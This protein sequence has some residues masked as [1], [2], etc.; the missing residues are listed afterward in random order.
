MAVIVDGFAIPVVWRPSDLTGPD[1]DGH[2][3][4]F[5]FGR[6]GVVQSIRA[7]VHHRVVGSLESMTN[8]TFYPTSDN[9]LQAGERRVS[10]HFGIGYWTTPNGEQLR[11]YQYV[12]LENTA[13]CNGQSDRDR[14]ACTWQLWISAG[15]PDANGMTVSI[16]H[17]DNGAL[18]GGDGR[19]VVR[20]EIVTASIA[21]DR[22]LLSG[23]AVAIRAAGIRCSDVAAAQLGRIHPST[24]TLV[25][26]KVVAP[27]SKPYCWRRLGDDAGFPQ[28]RYVR[29]LL[30][31]PTPP[32]GDDMPALTSYIPGQI[33]KVKPTANV[34]TAPKLNASIVRVVAA[35]GETWTVTGWVK[36]DVDPDG[37]SD[38][39]LIR[40]AGGRWEYTAKSN[41]T[42]GPTAQPTQAQLDA[43]V[44]AAKA[45]NDAEV[46][47]LTGRL[48]AI[49]GKVAATAVDIAND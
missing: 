10:S 29:E 4:R 48:T 15:R 17:E 44:A 31:P 22:L 14:T 32:T 38:R 41:V 2:V 1:S 21:L 42:S 27:I 40:W 34:R 3:G 25:D 24:Q 23:N 6:S 8:N 11:I 5:K 16:E 36:G 20:G 26:H 18:D 9:V 19:Y 37:G 13:Y 28:A 7:I 30:A 35:A 46:A 12:A 45:A 49:K 33:A 47:T 39:W 43:A